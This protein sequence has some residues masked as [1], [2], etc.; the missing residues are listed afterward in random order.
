M[1]RLHHDQ[2]GLYSRSSWQWRYTK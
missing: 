2:V 1:T